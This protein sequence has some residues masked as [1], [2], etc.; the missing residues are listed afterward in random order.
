MYK[1]FYKE[2]PLIITDCMPAGDSGKPHTVCEISSRADLKAAVQQFLKS[3]G[4]NPVT[5]YNKDNTDKLLS[6]LISLFWYLEAAGGIVRDSEGKRLC[7]YR[8]EKWDL[9]KGKLEAGEDTG[10]AAIREVAE[11][12]GITVRENPPSLPS[13]FH[14]YDH[15]GKKVLKKTY[16]YAMTPTGSQIPVPQTEEGIT[17]AEWVSIENMDMVLNNTYATLID[18]IRYDINLRH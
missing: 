7:I 15:K 11:E 18:L 4:L 10:E 8:F 2:H 17:K 3:Y 14:I 5:I 12:T 6:D 13:T 9:P 16:W 1:V